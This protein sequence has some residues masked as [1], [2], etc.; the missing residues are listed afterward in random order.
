MPWSGETR[1][2]VLAHQECVRADGQ[3]LAR[4]RVGDSSN[5]PLE[6]E[7]RNG[8]VPLSVLKRL[9]DAELSRPP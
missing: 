4:S 5:M 2:R 1:T 8:T 3:A 7:L 6:A 9:F